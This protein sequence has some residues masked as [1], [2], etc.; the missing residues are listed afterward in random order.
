MKV[1][2][3]THYGTPCIVFLG[4]NGEFKS[5]VNE[6]GLALPERDVKVPVLFT[7]VMEAHK[8]PAHAS[9]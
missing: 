8:E 7:D 1:Q 6:A 4:P 9:S 3:F 2:S 5:A